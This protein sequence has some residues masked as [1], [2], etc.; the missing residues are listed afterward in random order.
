MLRGAWHQCGDKSQRLIV[1]QLE[2]NVGVGVIL[3]PRD[4][5]K[6]KA[7]EYARAYHDLGAHV[8]IDQQFYEPQFSNSNISS[9]P[10]SSYR[11]IAS[12]P[13][14]LS[15]SYLSGLA[16]ALDLINKE[17]LSDAVIA[18][19]VVY[20]AGRQD[21][22]QLNSRLFS[23]AKKVG[24]TLGVPTYATA[25]FGRSC[26]GSDNTMNTVLSQLTSLSSDGWYFGFEFGQERIPSSYEAVLRCCTNGLT[27][28]CTGKPVLH[29]YAG[30]MALLSFGFGATA[31]AVGH[32]QNLWKFTHT[33]WRPQTG[34]GG[35][36]AAPPRFFS[37]KLWGTI[38]YPDEFAQLPIDLRNQIFNNSPFCASVSLDQ[39]AASWT[40]W[41]A[42]KHLVYIICSTS[43]NIANNKQPRAN[44]EA[45][46]AI[47]DEARLL[48]GQIASTGLALADSTN[49]YQNN[50]R[51]AMIELLRIRSKDFDYLKLLQ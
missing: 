4:V 38:I 13:D 27:L 23:I 41:N 28:A 43:G 6:H 11:A 21:I 35:G 31:T 40:R 16:T 12:Q 18:P 20:E 45:A 17:L 42:S 46:I 39:P 5:S 8:I 33:R 22:V 24:D 19:A 32:N 1:E 10:I 14:Q 37:S 44:A 51:L 48:H 29:A 9:Y 25:I 26:T 47:L 50:W 49:V 3:S 7:I 2:N 36:G 34:T 15:D 30:P